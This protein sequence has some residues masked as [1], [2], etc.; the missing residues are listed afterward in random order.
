MADSVVDVAYFVRS[1]QSLRHS[2]LIRSFS[3]TQTPLGILS[4]P[5]SCLRAPSSVA[6]ATQQVQSI[7]DHTRHPRLAEDEPEHTYDDKYALA[8]FVTNTAI[9]AQM[10]ALEKLGLDGDKWQTVAQW[11]HQDQKTVT[12]RWEAR[13]SCAFFKERDVDVVTFERSVETTSTTTNT[14]TGAPQSNNNNNNATAASAGGASA[15]G[16]TDTTSKVKVVT[17]VKEYH[18][19]V[20]VSHRL[21]VF[22][23][24]DTSAGL[25]LQSRTTSTFVVTSGGQATAYSPRIGHPNHNKPPTPIP[26]STIHLP[27][28]VNLT[29]FFQQI[30]PKEQVCQFHID[31][32]SVKAQRTCLTPR[33][34]EEIDAAFAFYQ[35]L[36]N[37]TGHVQLYLTSRLEHEIAGSHNPVLKHTATSNPEGVEIGSKALLT[38][39]Q[40]EP[41]FNGQAVIILEYSADT[42]RFR[43]EPVDKA[44]SGLPAT[45]L[46]KPQNL[47]L[48]VSSGP[49]L[50]SVTTHCLF[51]PV[52]PLM[53]NGSVFADVGELLNEQCRA[54]DG[55]IDSL[56]RQFPPRPLVKLVSVAEATV[57]LIALHLQD[58]CNGFQDG[59]DY[60]E[61]ML[62]QQLVAAIGKEISSKDFDQFMAFHQSKV[63]AAPFA[64]V[65]FTYAVRRPGHYPDGTFTIECTRQSNEPIQTMVRRVPK[66]SAPSM[67]LPINAATS[68]ELTGDRFLHGWMLH[69]FKTKPRNEYELIA[70]AR[71][72]SSFL[73][74]LGTLQ[75]PNKFDP[76]EAIILQNKDEVLIPLLTNTLPSAKEFKDSIASLSPEQKAFAQA[77]RGM[78]LESSVFGVCIIQLKPQLET[79]LGLPE[80]SLTKE[81]QLTQDLMS[82]FVEYQIPSDLLT[83]DGPAD[84]DAAAKVAAVKGYVKAILDM[85]ESAK[86]KQLLEEE[87][88]ADMR[89]EMNPSAGPAMF[90]STTLAPCSN[91][92]GSAPQRSQV[93]AQNIRFMA[94]PTYEATALTSAVPS[95]RSPLPPDTPWD[96]NK[97]R[98]APHSAL[99]ETSER[100][101]GSVNTR[102][103]RAKMQSLAS[104][105]S[106]ASLQV[107]AQALQSPSISVR[108]ENVQPPRESEKAKQAG[109]IDSREGE[110]FTLIPKL[111]DAKLEK[112]DVDNAL[113]STIIKAGTTW[114]LKR[115][116]NLLTPHAMQTLSGS[117]I[118]SE[119]TRAFDLLDAISRSGA[120][121][122][123]SS[124]LHVFIAVSHCFENDVM[125]CIVQD[126]VN[127]IEKVEK[128][129]LMIASTIYG[130][131][132]MTLLKDESEVQ[133]LTTTFP[134]LGSSTDVEIYADQE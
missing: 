1:R 21:F 38:G 84:A 71:Q 55:A 83:F 114:N 32:N 119:K 20:E 79:L 91:R 89:N 15:G 22:P 109:S 65:P 53:E 5:F 19:K 44:Q 17:K 7:L 24:T 98:P 78:Q 60:I 59:V 34:N 124:E 28:D 46:I 94:S 117:R 76:K 123:A 23:G 107:S 85:I 39:L 14:G 99:G 81:I 90:G 104:T 29:W 95:V 97:S 126:N 73:V 96:W 42:Q 45:L 100:S 41:T 70:R 69:R 36:Y 47:N 128:S 87:R 113:R 3:H 6:K 75:G 43:V 50:S 101:A 82:L 25:E 2:L 125:G 68:V 4:P 86:E 11:V 133:R 16:K 31:R 105:S 80:G 64:P 33:R 72:F 57:L 27:I 131:P 49:S 63:F 129:A 67:F 122:I 61:H 56:S 134:E 103:R 9:A 132:P 127:P 26:E 92:L 13:D 30:E 93:M 37:W 62:K 112:F 51:C 88:K 18:W 106:V 12:M 121:P 40:K 111:L 118:E 52:L 110:D 74:V 130:K 108:V 120:L 77:Y 48:E 66:D 35:Q 116:P 115:Q 58:L 8:E 102:S 54:L 10:N